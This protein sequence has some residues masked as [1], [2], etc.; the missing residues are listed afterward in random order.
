ME[1][2]YPTRLGELFGAYAIL[3]VSI[4]RW[5]TQYLLIDAKVIVEFSYIL[6]SAHDGEILWQTRQKMTYSPPNNF[7]SGT[8]NRISTVKE[9]V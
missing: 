6:K 5:E 7:N 3:Y 4:D 9:T 2:F 1:S 8:L